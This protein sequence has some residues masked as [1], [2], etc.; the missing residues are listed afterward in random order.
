VA[1]PDRELGRLLEQLARRGLLEQTI[2]CVTADHGEAFGE[3]GEFEHGHDLHREAV[4]VPWIVAGPGV[5]AG[6][7]IA[8]PVSLVDLAPTLLALAGLEVPAGVEG[9]SLFPALWAGAPPAGPVFAETSSRY[10]SRGE[11]HRAAYDGSLRLIRVTDP[12]GGVRA[13]A[14]Y[15]AASDPGEERPLDGPVTAG[16]AP[17]ALAEALDDYARRAVPVREGRDAVVPDL[18][19]MRALGYV[20]GATD[21]ESA[22]AAADAPRKPADPR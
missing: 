10:L 2:V 4:R 13:E 11:H 18:E 9:R 20:D 8:A 17:R 1:Y 12:D 3:R 14:Y 22:D 15:D 6:V 16:L 19:A 7:R 5:P 21:E